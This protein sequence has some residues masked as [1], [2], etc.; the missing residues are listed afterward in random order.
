MVSL[1]S[2]WSLSAQSMYD[3]LSGTKHSR[4]NSFKSLNVISPNVINNDFKTNSNNCF[5]QCMMYD[6]CVCVSPCTARTYKTEPKN[7]TTI[8]RVLLF[9]T[10][11]EILELSN[12]I[13]ELFDVNHSKMTLFIVERFAQSILTPKEN[14]FSVHNRIAWFE[15]DKW[16]GRNIKQ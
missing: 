5:I 4:Q 9:N 11:Y 1:S 7:C 16:H 12:W 3:P 13:L 15:N 6:V 10:I 8:T 14:T 2:A